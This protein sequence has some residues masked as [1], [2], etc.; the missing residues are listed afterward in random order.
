M[1]IHVIIIMVTVINIVKIVTIIMI[2]T[3]L[4]K[5]TITL[6]KPPNPLLPPLLV[7]LTLKKRFQPKVFVFRKELKKLLILVSKSVLLMAEGEVLQTC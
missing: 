6:F 4:Q 2:P 5:I 3:P 1:A 7:A